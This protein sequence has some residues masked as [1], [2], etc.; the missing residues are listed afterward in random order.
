[1]KNLS[2][3]L[4]FEKARRRKHRNKKHRGWK[5]DDAKENNGAGKLVED[6]ISVRIEEEKGKNIEIVAKN[7]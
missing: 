5:D 1:M 7:A 2:N 4:F 3:A 6:H